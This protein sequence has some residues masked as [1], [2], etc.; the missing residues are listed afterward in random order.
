MRS[1]RGERNSLFQCVATSDVHTRPRSVYVTKSPTITDGVFIITVLAAILALYVAMFIG[2][3]RWSHDT[4][5]L[6]P[7]SATA[8]RLDSYALLTM[9]RNGSLEIRLS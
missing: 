8:A 2:L 6:P 1:S 5:L 9:L 4:S 3:Y 7:D